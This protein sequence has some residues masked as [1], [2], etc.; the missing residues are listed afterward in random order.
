MGFYVC[1]CVHRIRTLVVPNK[2]ICA[3]V[4]IPFWTRLGS[5]A[6]REQFFIVLKHA[7]RNANLPKVRLVPT[8]LGFNVRKKH[9]VDKVQAYAGILQRTP[10]VVREAHNTGNCAAAISGEKLGK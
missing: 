9:Q 6:H 2:T 4:L 5:A 1:L 8:P 10:R 3:S 7:T